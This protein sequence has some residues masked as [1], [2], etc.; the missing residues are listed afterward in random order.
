MSGRKNCELRGSTAGLH[1]PASS[2][3]MRERGEPFVQTLSS[4]RARR[5]ET[6][7]VLTSD[8]ARADARRGIEGF[9]L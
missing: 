4:L 8:T 9:D 1:G 3:R 7:S 5:S 2:L 6:C